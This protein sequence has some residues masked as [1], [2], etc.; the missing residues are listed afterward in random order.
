VSVSRASQSSGASTPTGEDGATLRVALRMQRRVRI[1]VER[2]E[3]DIKLLGRPPGALDVA[4]RVSRALT[5]A[6]HATDDGNSFA[7]GDEASYQLSFWAPRD[8]GSSL[9]AWSMRSGGQRLN[10]AKKG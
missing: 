2:C 6:L 4:S 5:Q 3:A 8:R 7:S 1:H 10:L 9:R